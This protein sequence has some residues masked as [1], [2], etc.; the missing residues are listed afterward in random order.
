MLMRSMCSN[1]KPWKAARTSCL[2]TRSNTPNML[3]SIGH[4]KYIRVGTFAYIYGFVCHVFQYFSTLASDDTTTDNVKTLRRLHTLQF[5]M[6]FFVQ[7]R[8][9]FLS[10]FWCNFPCNC[11]CKLHANSTTIGQSAIAF[12]Y[13]VTGLQCPW[14]TSALERKITPLLLFVLMVRFSMQNLLFPR[15]KTAEKL[16]KK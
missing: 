4:L 8:C 16:I 13:V 6:Q 12:I 15:Q 1:E 7:F 11:R 9:K 5:L 3:E 14:V 2:F 10:H